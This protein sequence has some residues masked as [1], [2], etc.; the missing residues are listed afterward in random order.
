VLRRIWSRPG[1]AASGAAAKPQGVPAGTEWFAACLFAV[2]P[3][4][5]ESVAWITEQKNTLSMVFYLL[6]GLA[7]LD[8]STHR[9]LRTY[10]LASGLFLLALGSKTATVTLPAALLVVFWWRTGRLTWRRDVAPL[11]PWMTAALASGLF[12][13]WVERRLIGAEGLDFELPATLR[14]LLA[15]RAV[16]FYLG[17]L[18]WPADLNFF[19]PRWD[20]PADA[21]GWIGWL[22][23]AAALTVLLWWFRHQHRGPLAGWLLFVG[24]LFPVLGFFKVYFFIFSYVNDH[25]A[26]LASLSLI[27]TVT[28][29]VAL[30]LARTP[31]WARTLGAAAG[32]GIILGFALLSRAQSRLYTDNPTLFRATVERNPASWMGHHILGFALAKEPAHRAEAV[33]Q[34]REAL[35]L[36]PRYPDAHL[37]LAVEL[38]RLPGGGPEAIEHYERA[39]ALRPGYAEAHNDLGVALAGLPGRADEAV[40]HFEAALRL[41]PD[42]ALA[43]ANL[44]DALAS[45]PARRP[46]ALDHFAAALRLQPDQAGVEFKFANALAAEPGRAAEAVP[47]YER[48]LALDGGSAVAHFNLANTLARLP[49]R[50]ADAVPHYEAALRLKPDFADAHA[51]LANALSAIPGRASEAI[52][53]YEAALQIDPGLAW[54]HFNLA[55][56][57][58]RM[59]GHAADAVRHGE[60]AVRLKPDYVEAHNGLAIV[61]AQQGRLAEARRHWERALELDPT[62]EVARKNLELLD[63]MTQR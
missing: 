19:Y 36:N 27:A 33:V 21:G 56:Q 8:F 61:Y 35:R 2:H 55:L 20:V 38:A 31:A 4:C 24:A 37:G 47:H 14:V 18:V 12:T 46:E 23:A 28:G 52:A 60:E 49:G 43:H 40:A 22:A 50:L 53:H 11:L 59:P 10:V 26:Y 44:A 5:V 1:V 51:N 3:I 41:K 57:F 45:Q 9:R 58:A 48:A 7:Y 54:V 34:F 39:L 17:K 15:G 32:V 16:W 62:Y 63:R 30:F 42:F 6:A 29:A 13:S 25:F